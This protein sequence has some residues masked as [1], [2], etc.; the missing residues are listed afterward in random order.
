M[1]DTY[2]EVTRTSWFSRIK[3]AFK[4]ILGGFILIIGG[5][6]LLFW[7]EGRTV[8]NKRALQ[9]GEKA[10]ISVTAD[11]VNQTNDAKLIHFSGLATTQDTLTDSEFG[12]SELAIS[13]ERKVEMYQ[14]EENE[15]SKTDKK[16]GG[17]E[18][19]T[20]KYTYK[21]VWSS[22]L[23]KSEDFK[24]PN[25]HTNPAEFPYS[26]N[27]FYASVVKV[28][29][30]QL[31]EALIHSIPGSQPLT[32]TKLGI[33]SLKKV[34]VNNSVIYIGKGSASDPQIG[35]VKITYSIVKPQSI[36]IIGKQTQN[37]VEPYVA[38]NGNTVFI[39]KG[40][41]VSAEQMF[42]AEKSSN[43]RLGWILRVVGF[44]LIFMGFSALF[45]ILSVIGDVV[46]FIGNIIGFGTSLI[47][48]LLAF[49]ISFIVIAIAW[50]YYRPVIGISLLAIAAGSIVYVIVIGIRKKKASGA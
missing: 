9:E 31:P 28:G 1:S 32:I 48:G 14:W 26:S 16:L 37:S 27:A 30:F 3:N 20:T 18:E 50:I 17:A 40:G 8:K 5:I 22:S 38:K 6:V 45:K 44:F 2:T 43:N 47:S 23:N 10:V 25:R 24:V 15:E 7:N 29:A 4:G 36:S 13:L 41:I 42:K 12:I 21:K 11:A 46:P 34:S 35:D 49:G 39:L 19:T 33:D